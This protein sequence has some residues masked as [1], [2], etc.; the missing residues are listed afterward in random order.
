MGLSRCKNERTPRP[1]G[2]ILGEDK[3]TAEPP[4]GG[5]L[6]V[7]GRPAA[8]LLRAPDLLHIT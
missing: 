1:E 6:R 5:F 3:R 2:S 8:Q 7:F 4:N